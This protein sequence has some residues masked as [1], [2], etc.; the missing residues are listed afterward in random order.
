MGTNN[1]MDKC[2]PIKEA[3]GKNENTHISVVMDVG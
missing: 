1:L 3:D 2:I